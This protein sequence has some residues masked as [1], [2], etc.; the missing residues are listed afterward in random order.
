MV[1]LFIVNI[2]VC[3]DKYIYVVQSLSCVQL[4]VTPWT[5]ACQALLFSN[6]FGVCSNSRSLSH[7]CYLTI[8]SSAAPFSFC[9]L[10]FPS[11]GSFPISQLFASCC[12]SIGASASA[13]TLPMIIQGWFPLELTALICLQSKGLS[14]VISN[15]SIQKHQFLSTQLSLWSNSHIR[16][17][18]LEK[19]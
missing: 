18:L 5:A 11:W 15:T 6:L 8:W 14:R 4:F 12:Q 19:P 2:Y 9:L 13:S 3:I 17:W 10:S 7:W 16:T 1:L